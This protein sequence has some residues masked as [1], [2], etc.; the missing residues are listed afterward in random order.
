MAGAAVS[1]FVDGLFRGIGVRH[2]WQDRK[3]NQKRE[4]RRDEM[5][6][7]EHKRRMRVFD[8]NDADW[9]R[10]RADDDFY[11]KTFEE[12]AGAAD[13]AAGMGA[14]PQPQDATS[15]S[16]AGQPAPPSGA[17]A[18]SP[19]QGVAMQLGLDPRMVQP[20]RGAQMMERLSP[21]EQL[22]ARAAEQQVAPRRADAP[23]QGQ[24]MMG[25]EPPT[26]DSAPAQQASPYP[27]GTQARPDGFMAVPNSTA[28]ADELY[29]RGQVG[30]RFVPPAQVAVPEP[31]RPTLP[32]QSRMIREAIINSPSVPMELRDQARERERRADPGQMPGMGAMTPPAP[33]QAAPQSAP[34]A[35]PPSIPMKAAA[36][37]QEQQAAATAVQTLDTTATPEVKDATVAATQAMD[38]K[39]GQAKITEKQYARGSQ[40]WLDRYMEVG[41]PRVLEAFIS[42]GDFAKADAFQKF[43]QSSETRAGMKDWSKAA[44]AA[45]LG[46]MDTFGESIISAYNRMGYFPDGTTLVKGESGFTKGKDGQVNGAKLVFR[47]EKTGNTFEQVF[48]GPDDLIKTGITLMAP[49]SAF[50]FYW[51]E[52][53]AAAERA[54]GAMKTASELADKE[55]KNSGEIVKAAQDLMKQVN[56][57]TSG[58]RGMGPD[59]KP[60]PP[61]TLDE[62]IAEVIRARQAASRMSS[63][64]SGLPGFGGGQAG[65]GGA[66]G[67]WGAPAGPPVAYRP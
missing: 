54:M 46:D 29:Q 32:D 20:N 44:A 57:V 40:A 33:P 23:P 21:A 63:G 31:A 60:L 8:R 2:S 51:K 9:T 55:N 61:M 65:P 12:A 53:Q 14:M 18:A 24:R 67:S 11:R 13:Q 16:T 26:A 47:D 45:T 35:P 49:E 7:D 52:Q 59:G 15:T 62:A 37:P 66:S 39:P 41:A 1:G 42:R 6:E 36:S 58:G 4:D 48:S 30:P 27:P 64:G 25:F 19:A 17:P 22:A 5:T 3:R 28:I 34:A 43:M 50:E 38:V 56:D 10:A